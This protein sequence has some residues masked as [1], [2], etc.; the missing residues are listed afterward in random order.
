MT[1]TSAPRIYVRQ[2]GMSIYVRWLPVLNATD[3]NLYVKEAGGS[4]GLQ[5]EFTD[6][7]VND[8]G[9]FFTVETPFAGVVTVKATALNVLA[10]ESADSNEVQLNLT[11]AGVNHPTA[12]LRHVMKG[13]R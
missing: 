9:W 4:Y 11:G 10:E 13:A 6:D 7:D 1:A 3:Y 12:A 5:A 2:D 8:D